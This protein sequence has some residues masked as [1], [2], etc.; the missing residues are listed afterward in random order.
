MW[1]KSTGAAAALAACCAGCGVGGFSALA[2]CGMVWVKAGGAS[3]GAIGCGLGLRRLH[4]L[5]RIGEG[6]AGDDVDRH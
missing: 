6:C 1:L 3:T 4:G 5:A 2:G